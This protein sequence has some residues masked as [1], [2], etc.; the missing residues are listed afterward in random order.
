MADLCSLPSQLDREGEA[1]T[2]IL[3]LI[4]SVT[5]VSCGPVGQ[6]PFTGCSYPRTPIAAFRAPKVLPAKK[7]SS[8]PMDD[9]LVGDRP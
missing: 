1:Y 8:V 2:D 5:R 9:H 3:M 7:A 4:S 6:E